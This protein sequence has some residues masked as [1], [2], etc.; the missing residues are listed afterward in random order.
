[1][2]NQGPRAIFFALKKD[3]AP[4]CALDQI[5]NILVTEPTQTLI[6][7]ERPEESLIS[8]LTNS[9]LIKDRV[10]T[11]FRYETN[12]QSEIIDLKTNYQYFV[13]QIHNTSGKSLICSIIT[14]F[15]ASV[16]S[17]GKFL[18]TSRYLVVN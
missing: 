17:H 1:M 6:K 18:V 4:S 9:D 14:V 13:V 10:I 8:A 16:H 15:V 3:I 5:I 7:F 11:Q 2:L 12:L